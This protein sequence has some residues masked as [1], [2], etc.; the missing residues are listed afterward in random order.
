MR[1]ESQRRFKRIM[2]VGSAV[3]ILVPCAFGFIDKFVQ[4]VRVAGTDTDGSF[5]LIPMANYV[6]VA[7]GFLCL[8]MWAITNGMFRDIEAPKY[9]MLE[10]EERLNRQEGYS[11]SHDQ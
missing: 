8:L 11:W 3:G 4:F 1:V 6:L 2:L 5:A 9:N 7:L 10:R